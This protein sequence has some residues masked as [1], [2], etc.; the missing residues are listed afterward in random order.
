M[1]VGYVPFLIPRKAIHGTSFMGY[2]I[3]KGTQA[4]VNAWA[5]GRDP[6]CWDDPLSFKPGKTVL[7]FTLY[8][9]GTW[10]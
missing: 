4:L 9:F 1:V 7:T 10:C 8:P 3:P 6:K 2:D 5:I